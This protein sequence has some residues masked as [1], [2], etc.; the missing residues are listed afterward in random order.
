[1]GPTTQLNLA[2]LFDDDF[3]LLERHFEAEGPPTE[4]ALVDAA[5][6][7]LRYQGSPTAQAHLSVIQALM[8]RWELDREGLF[9][10]CRAIW[11]SQWRPSAMEQQA[12]VG[13]GADVGADS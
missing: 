13:S 3:A 11:A 2:A 9:L 8:D 6:L 1:M 12:G 7:L 5:R 4:Q 10:M